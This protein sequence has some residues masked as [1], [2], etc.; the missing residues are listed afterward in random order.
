METPCCRV[1]GRKHPL[2]ICK[3]DHFHLVFICKI[4]KVFDPFVFLDVLTSRMDF[5]PE[6]RRFSA[7]SPS[8]GSRRSK[9]WSEWPKNGATR[10]RTRG[11]FRGRSLW[12]CLGWD[13]GS[14]FFFWF[15]GAWGEGFLAF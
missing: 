7:L 8:P 11:T 5:Q 14:F 15:H 3:I 9:P 10:S 4:D 13:R 12:V 2:I 6:K 1:V